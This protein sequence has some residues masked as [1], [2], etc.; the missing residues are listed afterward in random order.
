MEKQKIKLIIAVAAL[1]LL[2]AVAGVL[3]SR[4]G[5][6]YKPG[7]L[8]IDSG[9]KDDTVEI[10]D[11]V[12]VE[13]PKDTDTHGESNEE[14][15]EGSSEEGLA[16]DFAMTDRDGNKV[17][18]SDFRGKPVILNFWASWCP[19]CQGEMPDFDAAY[20]NYGDRVNFIML[21][22][23]DGYRETVSTAESFINEKGYGFPV[24]FDTELEGSMNYGASSIP[25]TFFIDAQGRMVAYGMGAIGKAELEQG[26][27]MLL[28]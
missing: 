1:V 21:N 26:M 2:I 8:V 10:G 4:L 22:V 17:K 25:M 7:K 18:L 16:P 15:S 13:L 11:T 5:D 20:K 28:N 12:K 9:P 3:Y 6:K 27:G 14:T 23:T 24:Y 19:P